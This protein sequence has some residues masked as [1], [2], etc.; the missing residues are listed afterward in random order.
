MSADQLRAAIDAADRLIAS[1]SLS[2][3]QK[4][5]AERG[6]EEAQKKLNA[7]TT[8]QPVVVEKKKAASAATTAQT[9]D[10]SSRPDKANNKPNQSSNKGGAKSISIDV[11]LSSNTDRTITIKYIGR[12]GQQIEECLLP[13]ILMLKFKRNFIQICGLKKKEP[14]QSHQFVPAV[15]YLA[16][17]DKANRKPLTLSDL[18]YKG[19]DKKLVFDLLRNQVNSL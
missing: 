5:L 1:T 14:Q 12:E 6:K 15:A 10:S 4:V 13:G 11:S 2:Q 9:V 18:G 7:L 3:E 19:K 8:T 17:L 16:A